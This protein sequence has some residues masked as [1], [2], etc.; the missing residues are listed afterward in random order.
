MALARNRFPGDEATVFQTSAIR[1]STRNDSS[2]GQRFSFPLEEQNE[3]HR[4]R[5]LSRFPRFQASTDL[6]GRARAPA[7]S[8]LTNHLGRGP[9]RSE[10]HTSELQS[11]HD[12]VCRLLLEKKK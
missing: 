3:E 2:S 9:V 11:H 4:R 1:E 7:S 12:L 6:I 5:R 10:E 8:P